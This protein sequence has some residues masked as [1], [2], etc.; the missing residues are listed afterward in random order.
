MGRG[1]PAG[2]VASG[3]A[4]LPS[5]SA[6]GAFK[7]PWPS[8][9]I[10]NSHWG[11]LAGSLPVDRT[12]IWSLRSSISRSDSKI[13]RARLLVSSERTAAAS[14]PSNLAPSTSKSCP[15]FFQNVQCLA[16]EAIFVSCVP[17]LL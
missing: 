4:C 8:F 9:L 12:I 13:S 7:K 5:L 17:K 2:N 16:I 10:S 6:T 3:C 11:S 1:S 14:R 15:L